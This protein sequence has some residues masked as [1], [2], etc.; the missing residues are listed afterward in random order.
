MKT[1]FS[2]SVKNMNGLGTFGGSW[3]WVADFGKIAIERRMQDIKH[4]HIQKQLKIDVI[5]NIQ[6]VY[7]PS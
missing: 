6:N 3:T 1:V 5:I 7:M 4:P 2:K